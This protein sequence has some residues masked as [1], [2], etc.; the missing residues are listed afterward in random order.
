MYCSKKQDIRGTVR[1]GGKFVRRTRGYLVFFLISFSI[2]EK[3]FTENN[4]LYRTK[5]KFCVSHKPNL[6]YYLQ[7]RRKEQNNSKT[8]LYK[9]VC[10]KYSKIFLCNERWKKKIKGLKLIYQP[11]E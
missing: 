3:S 7:V 10:F 9:R 5:F 8:T 4:N 2:T 11:N 6:I 1:V